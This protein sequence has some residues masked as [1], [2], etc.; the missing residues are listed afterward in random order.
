MIAP[1]TSSGKYAAS[2]GLQNVTALPADDAAL[3]FVGAASSSL[4]QSIAFHPSAFKM[5]TAP[6]FAPKGV[7]LVATETVDGI[8]VNIVRDFDVKTRE[9]ITRLDV[10]YAFDDV[11][12]EWATLLTA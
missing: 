5:A 2:G 7:D 10:L 11:R 12:P 4:A 8:T 6:L 3:V 9:V 1:K